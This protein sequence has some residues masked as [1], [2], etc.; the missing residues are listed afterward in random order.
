MKRVYRPVLGLLVFGLLSSGSQTTGWGADAQLAPMTR[1]DHGPFVAS[2]IT[3]DPFSP[4]GIIVQKGIAVR[5][6]REATMVYDTDLLRVVGAWTGGL[7]HW[8]EARDSLQEWPTPDGH[9]H[10][11]NAEKAGWS[12]NGDLSDPR[13]GSVTLNN[14]RRAGPLPG[15]MRYEGLHIRGDDVVFSLAVGEAKVRE[16]FGFQRLAGNPIFTRTINV[17]PTSQRLTLVVVSAP[18]GPATRLEQTAVSPDSGIVAI[19][20]GGEARLIGY[21]GLPGEARWQ[22]EAGHLALSLPALPAALQFQ[23]AIGPVGPATAAVSMSALLQPDAG[24]LD[25]TPYLTPGPARYETL[26]TRAQ[27][28]TS[29]Y[30]PFVVDTLLLPTDN[31]WRAHLRLSAVDFLSDGRAVVASLSGDV[32]LVSGIGAQLGTL[33]WQRFAAGLNQ[34]LGLV[35]VNDTIYVNGRDQITRLHDTNNDGYADHYENFNNAVMAG[36]N[37]HAFNLNLEVDAH[38]RF[39]WAKSTPWPT[40]NPGELSDAHQTTPHDGVLFRLSPD[41]RQ[42]E[43]VARGLRNPNGLSIGPKGEIY[44]S[45]NEGNWVPT[46]KVTRIVEGGFHGF[47]PSAHRASLV[48]GWTPGD[49]WVKPLVWTPHAGPGSD[50]SPSQARVI[51]SPAWPRELQ[52]D[53]L[54]A[55]Y[56]RG[57]LSLLLMEEVDGQPQAAHMTLPLKFRSGLQHMRFHRDQHLYVVGMTNWSSTSHGGDRG[58]FQRVRFT[59]GK[60]LHVPVA[61]HT[62]PGG[63]ELQFAEPLDR[64][65]ATDPANFRLS[66]WTYA[67][68]SSYGSK[69]LFSIDRPGQPGPD[70]LSVQAATL[71]ADGRTLRLDIPALTPGP[72]PR[73][74]LTGTLPHQIEAS[75]GMVVRI[76]YDIRAANGTRLKQLV[77]KTI[78]RVP[79]VPGS[80]SGAA[81]TAGAASP[82]P[83]E[84]QTSAGESRSQPTRTAVAPVGKTPVGR[85]VVVRSKGTELTY[86][87]AVID[88]RAGETLTIR[89]ENLGEMTHNIVV[90]KSEQDIPV[91][92]EAAFQAAFTTNWIPT[93]PEFAARMLA[94]TPLAAAKETVEVTFTVPPPG[95]YPFICTFA[96]HWTLMRGRL[97]VSP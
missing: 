94:Y 53:L 31:P 77:H 57:T 39:L 66:R 17:S 71:S 8:R 83:P 10:F 20:S 6:G 3:L 11:L 73:V 7:L 80:A 87:P 59:A 4:K 56:G 65:S 79:G 61:L 48:G 95:E 50:N 89:Y 16:K 19:H 18:V 41:G 63:L 75:L 97:S 86:E 92:G 15:N 64:R 22:L 1:M 52:G 34:P 33:R 12:A 74:P 46:S 76:D 28:A 91:I 13:G 30:G 43:I 29:E 5:V 96:S 23:I 62:K 27:M 69:Q 44:V 72:T 70:P 51:D 84:P 82:L 25:L 78:H 14:A 67:W 37:F 32:W 90:V 81:E 36:T 45:D 38:G 93:G 88:A 54:L 47:V 35:V 85:V 24:S 40:G 9:L 55:S 2:T 49:D 68:N 58:G 42:L 26:E 60:P 21:R